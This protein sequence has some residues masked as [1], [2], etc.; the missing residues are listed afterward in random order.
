LFSVASTAYSIGGPS[1]AKPVLDRAFGR[2]AELKSAGERYSACNG[3]NH[4]FGHGSVFADGFPKADDQGGNAVVGIACTAEALAIPAQKD[5]IDPLK[6]ALASSYV[7]THPVID[8]TVAPTRAA[9][10]RLLA[11]A[12]GLS[13]NSRD[14]AFSYAADRLAREGA[15]ETALD[16]A[17]F[18]RSATSYSTAAAAVEWLMDAGDAT[19]ARHIA[20]RLLEHVAALTDP[21][22][23]DSGNLVAV[24][25]L[26]ALGDL[27][28]AA[29]AAA[30]INAPGSRDARTESGVGHGKCLM[31]SIVAYRQTR[32]SRTR[33]GRQRP[34]LV[35]L[36]YKRLSLMRYPGAIPRLVLD[37]SYLP[38]LSVATQLRVKRRKSP[39]Q[40]SACRR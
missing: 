23:K 16:L 20:D 7:V 30:D 36:Q 24:N 9:I 37:A 33:W 6:S 4:Y 8:K 34:A 12:S 39:R 14:Y 35:R 29:K 1:A 22:A 38:S 5:R 10:S 26:V 2:M 28:R 18:P 19:T 3:I 32:F 17:D 13:P 11:E 25:L 31:G 40:C 15:I 27:E 21:A